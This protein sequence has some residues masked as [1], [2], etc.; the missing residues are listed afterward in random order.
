MRTGIS[1]PRNA[2]TVKMAFQTNNL[3]I[4]DEKIDNTAVPAAEVAKA[5]NRFF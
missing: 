2:I 5:V 3:A 4:F 1:H